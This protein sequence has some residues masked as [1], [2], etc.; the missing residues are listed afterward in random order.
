M[1]FIKAF[2]FYQSIEENCSDHDLM[3]R[4]LMRKKNEIQEMIKAMQ[5]SSEKL[6][7]EL[8]KKFKYLYLFQKFLLR[9]I[10]TL[11][12]FTVKQCS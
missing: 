10:S 5:E 3:L 1:L 7:H 12:T 9:L 4:G 11:N 8:N 2:N 6:V